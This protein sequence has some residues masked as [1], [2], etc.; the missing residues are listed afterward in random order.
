MEYKDIQKE[1]P[2]T[3]RRVIDDAQSLQR[4]ETEEYLRSLCVEGYP[5]RQKEFW[6][7]N[8]S[9]PESFLTSVEPNRQRWEQ[10]VG[11]FQP[12]GDFEAGEEPFLEDEK[13]I[14]KRISIKFA[15]NLYCRFVFA[16]PKKRAGKIPL[17]IAQHGIS[18]SPEKVFGLCDD[19]N[20]YHSYGYRLAKDGF[21]VIAP[22][23]IT[24]VERKRY[25]RLALLL[26]KT[27]VGLEISKLKRLLDYA[28]T[29]PE[30][31]AEKIAMWGISLGGYYT[32]LAL[33][34]EPRL[35]A[36]IACAFFNHRLKKMV[37]DD[38]RYS[39]FLSTEEEH[40]FIP[41]WLREFTDSD[42]VSLICPRP[43][44]VQTGKADGVSWW[45]FV[46]EE[47]AV[48]KKHYD[49]LGMADR[50][51]MDLH[52]GGHEIRYESGLAFLK[53]WMSR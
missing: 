40:I 2:D 51:Q 29:L 28:S 31:D 10:A 21:A 6:K 14:A 49:K 24:T 7:R 37:I 48:A 50:I 38:P 20:I 15:P 43:F 16:L 9:S 25:C 19:G 47:F 33:P 41:G 44:M 52:S 11:S 18:C 26:G 5:A 1:R 23:N 8:Y 4:R 27:L 30:V 39:C 34:L 12:E 22:L 42:L 32:L 17:V 46:L 3:I 35:K 13:V 45:P 36:G 53:K